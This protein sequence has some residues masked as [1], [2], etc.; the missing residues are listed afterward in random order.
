MWHNANM[1]NKIISLDIWDTILKRKCHPEEIKLFTAKYIFLKYNY[2]LKEKFKDIYELLKKRDEIEAEICKENQAKGLDGECRI[3]DVFSRLKKDIFKNAEDLKEIEQELLEQEIQKEIDMVYLNNDLVE[4]LKKYEGA[5]IYCISDFYMSADDLKRIID[6]VNPPFK[7]EKIYSSADYLLNKKSGRLYKKFEEDLGIQPNEHLHI[8]DNQI[9]DIQNAKKIGIETIKIENKNNIQFENKRERKFSFGL[10]NAKIKEEKM[11]N[12]LFNLGVELS[13]LL[14]LFNYNIIEYA[15]KNKIDRVYY[16]TREGERFIKGHEIISKDNP[17][18]VKIP[19]AELLEVS[20]MATFSASLKEFSIA[21]MLRLWSQYRKQSMNALFKTL[22][23]DIKKYKKY[24]EKYDLTVNEE[25]NEPWFDIRVQ[26]L[27]KDEEFLKEINQELKQKRQELEKYFYKKNIVNENGE[28]L[29]VDIG[30]RGTIQDNIA[31]I[32]PKKNITGYYI[33]LYDFY[34]YQPRNTKK[35]K[36]IKNRDLIMNDISSIITVLEML[37]SSNTGSVI[38]YKDGKAIRKLK[39]EE[40]QT[41]QNYIEHIQSGM[42]KGCKTINEYMKIHPYEA[43]EF[44][45]YIEKIIKSIK[46][47]PNKDLVEVYYDLV[48]NDTFGTGKYINKK[49]EK[50]GKLERLNIFKCRNRLRKE[51]WKEA[52]IKYNHIEYINSLMGVKSLLRKITGRK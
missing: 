47:N 27:C 20:R 19:D 24:I 32:F 22:A 34:N 41:V 26:N 25:I 33:T 30:W 43:S 42:L 6:S 12:R 2:E 3:L 8:G 15:I 9:S 51:L 49:N 29:I 28:M 31:Y 17:L 37:F 14:Y 48:M 16:F 18:S 45:T 50:L 4:I 13:P 23:I 52:Y 38:E 10:E 39:K 46:E 44:D 35:I 36:F 5:K 11:E 7:I 21:E 1:E 40:V